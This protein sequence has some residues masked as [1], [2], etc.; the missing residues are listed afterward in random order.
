MLFRSPTMPRLFSRFSKLGKVMVANVAV[1]K[2]STIIN[3]LKLFSCHVLGLPAPFDVLTYGH[4]V[5]F[6]PVVSIIHKLTS[7]RWKYHHYFTDM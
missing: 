5:K 7:A 6:E 4:E 3:F 2:C 1:L